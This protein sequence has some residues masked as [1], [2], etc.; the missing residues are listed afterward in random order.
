MKPDDDTQLALDVQVGWGID[1]EKRRRRHLEMLLMYRNAFLAAYTN[2]QKN[3][4][5]NPTSSVYI[6][7][8]EVAKPSLSLRNELSELGFEQ[9]SI[10]VHQDNV[11]YIKRV[12]SGVGMHFKKCKY[13]D[14]QHHYIMFFVE[15]AV[16][17][18]VPTRIIDMKADFLIKALP[19]GNLSREVSTA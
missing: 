18:L 3:V 4:S 9:R 13:L 16:I 15:D 8:S 11:K 6:A 2:L 19:H 14:V 17:A 1:I 5:L 10:R 7:L 12:K